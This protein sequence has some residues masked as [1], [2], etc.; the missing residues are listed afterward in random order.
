MDEKL[1]QEMRRD[2]HDAIGYVPLPEHAKEA[3]DLVELGGMRYDLT[4][5]SLNKLVESGAWKKTRHGNKTF[6]WK[7][8][9]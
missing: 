2:L 4:R 1:L 5:Q 3:K 7:V 8:L 9:S 6:Y